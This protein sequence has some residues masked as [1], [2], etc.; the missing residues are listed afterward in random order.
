MLCTCIQATIYPH[1]CGCE[2]FASIFGAT[3][4]PSTNAV[5]LYSTSC[6]AAVSTPALLNPLFS[7][8]YLRCRLLNPSHPVQLLVS[9][10]LVISQLARSTD[11]YYDELANCGLLT[12]LPDLLRHQDATVRARSCNLL[13]NLCRH[14]CGDLPT[15]R[16]SCQGRPGVVC[17]VRGCKIAGALWVGMLHAVEVKFSFVRSD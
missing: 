9:G 5:H 8:D 1:R 10:L 2:A 7:S 3:S 15:M 16:P 4:M 14:R 6:T 13:G 11:A 12:H 17:W